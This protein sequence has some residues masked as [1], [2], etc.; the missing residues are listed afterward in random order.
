[1][2]PQRQAAGV[3][4]E[5]KASVE[6]GQGAS[7]EEVVEVVDRDQPQGEG[8]EPRYQ[9]YPSDIPHGWDTEEAD[10]PAWDD[11]FNN[12]THTEYRVNMILV[13]NEYHERRHMF[14]AKHADNMQSVSR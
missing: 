13:G 7:P 3:W 5:A 10:V 14:M 6:K 11:N 8:D 1:M 2:Q 4:A 12:D 9:E